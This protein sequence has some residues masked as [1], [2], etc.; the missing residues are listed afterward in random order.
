[1]Y[2]TVEFLTVVLIN[3]Q[4]FWNMMQWRVICKYQHFRGVCFRY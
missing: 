4:I 1:M 2:A 3:I